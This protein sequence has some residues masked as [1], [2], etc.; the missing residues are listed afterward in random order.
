[1]R[2]PFALFILSYSR[3]LENKDVAN[4]A[5]QTF[6]EASMVTPRVSSSNQNTQKSD[7]IDIDMD[8]TPTAGQGSGGNGNE[9]SSLT[10][11]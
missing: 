4:H 10:S 5:N 2:R 7:V 6:D 1:M 9:Q 3:T 8:A 11:P